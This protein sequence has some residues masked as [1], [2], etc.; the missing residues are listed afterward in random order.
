MRKRK[1]MTARQN[2]L[3]LVRLLQNFARS[4]AQ[5]ARSAAE[6]RDYERALKL[7]HYSLALE[8]FRRIIASPTRVNRK[9]NAARKRRTK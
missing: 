2:R 7:H 5:D 9:T 3:R 6:N 8:E 4:A 1:R